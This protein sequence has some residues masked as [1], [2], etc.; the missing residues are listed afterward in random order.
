MQREQHKLHL[1][2]LSEDVS[3][4]D[5]E[6]VLLFYLP[7]GFRAGCKCVVKVCVCVLVCPPRNHFTDHATDNRVG[8][9]LERQACKGS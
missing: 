3:E 2:I 9:Y 4:D 1:N 7:H 5:L 6:R 8:S